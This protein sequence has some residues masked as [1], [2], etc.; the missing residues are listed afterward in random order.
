MVLRKLG[1][2]IAARS[3]FPF[4]GTDLSLSSRT[5]MREVK[6]NSVLHTCSSWRVFC[7]LCELRTGKIWLSSYSEWIIITALMANNDEVGLFRT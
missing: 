6:G 5:C 4:A 1:S 3:D 7:T 2:L